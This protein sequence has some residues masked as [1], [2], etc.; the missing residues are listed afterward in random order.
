M[1]REGNGMH[2]TRALCVAA[3]VLPAVA[4]AQESPPSAEN[5]D[6]AI[7]HL[8]SRVAASDCT[9]IRNRT[10]YTGA[11]A[12]VH[13]AR[14]YRYFKDR[15]RT[16]EDFIRLAATKSIQTGE[17]Y[18]V[19]TRDG[20]EIRSEEWMLKALGD[21]R[22]S[23]RAAGDGREGPRPDPHTGAATPVH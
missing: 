18:T 10:A 21:Y 13:M 17:P 6:A 15:I 23:A 22:D 14:K 4:L 16:P 11:R 7:R 2:R 1:N 9:F 19:R 12:S 8:I 20:T 5:A 3:L